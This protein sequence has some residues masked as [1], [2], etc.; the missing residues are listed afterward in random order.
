MNYGRSRDFF[1]KGEVFLFY[2]KIQIVVGR[3]IE[4]PG[5]DAH[6]EVATANSWARVRATEV[7]GKTERGFGR[8]NPGIVEMDQ[9]HQDGVR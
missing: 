2:I 4:Y 6:P 3:S 7:Q 5:F 1:S 8:P 9:Q